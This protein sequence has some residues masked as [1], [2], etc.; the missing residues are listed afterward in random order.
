MRRQN[1]G[2]SCRCGPGNPATPGE[3]RWLPASSLPAAAGVPRRKEP[4][5]FT[6]GQFPNNVVDELGTGDGLQILR[7][8][9]SWRWRRSLLWWHFDSILGV[10]DLATVP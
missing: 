3:L 10:R 7:P 9:Q 4:R 5:L 2:V 1:L 8:Y 6:L